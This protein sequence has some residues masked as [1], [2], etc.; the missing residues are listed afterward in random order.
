MDYIDYFEWILNSDFLQKGA[1]AL[2]MIEPADAENPEQR[3]CVFR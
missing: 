2:T 1:D 3:V